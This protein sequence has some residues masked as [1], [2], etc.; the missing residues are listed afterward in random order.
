MLFDNCSPFLIP[1]ATKATDGVGSFGG[2]GFF[3]SSLQ[4]KMQKNYNFSI[5]P[6]HHVAQ[7]AYKQLLHNLPFRFW[8]SSVARVQ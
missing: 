8:Q 3:S 5:I 7:Q 4:A 2:S 6:E 1:P